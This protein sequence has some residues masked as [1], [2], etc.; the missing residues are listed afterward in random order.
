LGDTRAAYL[1]VFAFQS[2]MFL[3][4]ALVAFRM[5]PAGVQT[6]NTTVDNSILWKGRTAL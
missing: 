2:L 5:R 4:S 1:A 6:I 3:A